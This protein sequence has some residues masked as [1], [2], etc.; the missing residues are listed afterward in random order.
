MSNEGKVYRSE[1]A[2]IEPSELEILQAKSKAVDVLSAKLA[3]IGFDTHTMTFTDQ[4]DL[5][6]KMSVDGVDSLYVTRVQ[7]LEA[8]ELKLKR[9]KHF[10]PVPGYDPNRP[11]ESQR[12][13]QGRRK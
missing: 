11:W 3:E 6:L 13:S 5:V 10:P 4:V 8:A 12:K 9:G 2:L 7:A 1:F